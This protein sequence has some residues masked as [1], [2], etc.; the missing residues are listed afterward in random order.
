MGAQPAVE[1]AP[2]RA[3]TPSRPLAWLAAG[4]RD[5]WRT[6]LLSLAHGAAMLLGAA[7]ILAI[8]RGN[9]GLLAGAFSG[10]ALLA[11]LLA[12]GLY[13]ISRRLTLGQPAD[14]GAVADAWLRGGWAPVRLGLLLAAIG[15]AW[16]GVSVIVVMSAPLAAGS[17]VE[18]FLRYFALA[19]HGYRLLAWLQAGGMVAATV[20]A[21]AA[22]SLPMLLDRQVDLRRAVLT[23]VAAVGANP[24]TMAA[25]AGLIMA[26]TLAG[27]ATVLGL[28]VIV[29]WLGHATWHAY[30]DAVD[31][32]AFA[33]RA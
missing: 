8:G 11:P 13:E 23:S 3:L 9:F 7:G 21:I 10:F 20:F 15:S 25:W 33:A 22:V 18:A 6:P 26:L 24:V 14:A 32:S 4:W 28:V 1:P 16:V 12:F 5:L 27:M 30:R 29:P 2:V 17:G 19:D 31:A